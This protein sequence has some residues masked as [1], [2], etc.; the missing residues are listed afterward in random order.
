MLTPR[1]L[2]SVKSDCPAARRVLLP[3]DDILLGLMSGTRGSDTSLQRAAHTGTNLGIAAPELVENGDRAKPRTILQ[4][5]PTSLSQ[6]VANG[7]PPPSAWHLLLRRKAAIQFDAVSGGGV[8]RDLGSGNDRRVSLTET[9]E[10]PYI[11]IGDVAAGQDKVSH[12]VK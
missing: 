2:M 4:H 7:S 5:L 8:E 3:E 11:A 10:Q 1:S 9:H 6:T 12:R